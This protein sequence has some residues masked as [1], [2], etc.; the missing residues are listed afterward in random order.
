MRRSNEKLVPR[1]DTN[2]HRWEEYA[3][4]VQFILAIYRSRKEV[5]VDVLHIVAVEEVGDAD[6]ELTLAAPKVHKDKTDP[7]LEWDREF[8]LRARNLLYNEP[9]G[10]DFGHTFERGLE[11]YHTAVKRGLTIAKEMQ[12][13]GAA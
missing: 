11:R 3:D 4:A 8:R 7:W 1:W 13:K 2:I 6:I 12:K 9:L 10:P 5:I